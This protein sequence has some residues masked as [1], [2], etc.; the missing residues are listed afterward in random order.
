MSYGAEFISY[1]KKHN[2]RTFTH[3]DIIIQTNTNCPYSVLQAVRAKLEKEGQ[4]IEEIWEK[5]NNK[6]YKRYWIEAVA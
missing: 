2:L 1:L 3:K 4:T 6:P 5:K